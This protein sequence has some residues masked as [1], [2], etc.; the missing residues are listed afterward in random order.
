MRV[1]LPIF[2]KQ[3]IENS[4][5]QPDCQTGG[6]SIFD[7]KGFTLIELLVVSAIIVILMVIALASYRTF[8]HQT[9]VETSAQRILSTLQLARN[10]TVASEEE[11]VYGVHFEPSKYVLFKGATYDPISADNKEY[12]LDRVGLSVI[13]LDGGGRE[14]VFDRVRG[15]TPQNGYIT[16]Q[17]INEP[18]RTKTIIINPLG[19]VSL[20]ETVNPTGARIA[21]TRHLHYDLGWSI[22]NSTTLRFVFSDTTPVT[23]DIAMA[24]YFD[25]GKTEFSWEGTIDVNGSKQ[26]LQVKTH[27]LDATN[28]ILSIH[29]DRRYN[30]KAVQILID[31]KEIVSYTAAGEAA[32][33]TFGGVATQQ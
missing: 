17:L 15:T 6:F 16:V 13:S 20:E 14:V 2:R 31:G 7:P 28:T 26:V 10:Q 33:G 19:Q 21:D 9:D 4:K 27:L 30:D 5:Q 1:N 3:Q 32:V 23:K 29:R 25:V 22:Q 8:G 18:T 11:T 24:T 12:T